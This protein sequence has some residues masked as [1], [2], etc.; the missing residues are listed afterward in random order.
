MKPEVHG[1][2]LI[3]GAWRSDMQDTLEG[4]TICRG[5]ETIATV[6]TDESLGDEVDPNDLHDLAAGLE[7]LHL[8]Q[9]LVDEEGDFYSDAPEVQAQI[10]RFGTI[11]AE[12]RKVVAASAARRTSASASAQEPT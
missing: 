9:Q 4:F 8:A 5:P 10:D 7:C 2:F 6:L 3:D 11:V 1:P 12:M